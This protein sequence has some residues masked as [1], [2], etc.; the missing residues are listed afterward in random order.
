MSEIRFGIVGTGMIANLHAK[1][2]GEASRA[3]LTAVYD[4]TPENARVFAAKHNVAADADLAAFIARRDVD[5]I[6]IATPSGARAEVAVAAAQ[7]GKHLLC[8]K[9]LEVTVERADRIIEACSENNVVL[10]CVFQSR[11][12][13]NVRRI[14]EALDAGRFGRLVLVDV[15]VPWFRTQEYYDSATWRGTWELDGGGALMNQGIHILDL[16]L[17]F[18]GPAHSVC[19][20]TDALTH[21]GVEVE[22]TA[23]ATV[24]F[25]NGALGTIAASTSCP[26]GFPRRLELAGGKGSVVLEDDRLVRWSFVQETGE[27]ER[28]RETG[29]RGD[30]LRSGAGRP[31][32]IAHE[33]H[34]RLIDDLAEAILNGREPLIPGREGRRAVEFICGIYESARTQRPHVFSESNH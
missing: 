2:I 12:G 24:R 20:F 34:R 5:A 29:A 7:A 30:G 25:V 13:A 28:I 1:A 27:D 8:E 18:A 14:R 11:T 17:H 9:P 31:D 4:R 16:L 15:Q 23:A 19:A 21:R 33:G 22:D 32:S 26:P 10:A 3:R 6:T